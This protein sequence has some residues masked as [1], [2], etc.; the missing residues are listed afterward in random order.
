MHVNRRRSAHKECQTEAYGNQGNRVKLKDERKTEEG[1]LDCGILFHI[2]DIWRLMQHHTKQNFGR[3]KGTLQ[4]WESHFSPK[5]LIVAV[6]MYCRAKSAPQ[7]SSSC[8]FPAV[9]ASKTHIFQFIRNILY[10]EISWKVPTGE[11]SLYCSCLSHN[12]EVKRG[13]QGS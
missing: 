4:H 13:V 12:M 6:L 1:P 7:I 9:I 3:Y 2:K 11:I 10:E 8:P 5:L